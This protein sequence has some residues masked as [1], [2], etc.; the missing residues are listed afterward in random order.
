MNPRYAIPIFALTLIPSTA[1]ANA[2][3][4]LMW[5]SMLHLVFGNF[6]IGMI[7]GGLLAKIFNCSK[8]K[9]VPILIGA[10]YASAWA[11][12]FL[13]TRSLTSIP[14]LT[15]QNI[16]LWFLAFVAVA[17]L[18]TLLIEFPFFWFILRSK[19]KP[20]MQSIKATLLIHGISYILLFGWYWMASGT[21]M[22]TQLQVVSPNTLPLEKGY[23]LYYLSTEGN[24][25]L[26]LDLGSEATP[27]VV[28][29]ISAPH[30]NDRLFVRANGESNFDLFAHLDSD[31]RG[32]EK[33]I[34]ITPSFAEVAPVE[35]RIAEGHSEEAEGTWFNFGK[36]PSLAEN[37]AWEFRTGF[38]PIEGIKGEQK[39]QNKKVRFSLETPF[40][41][42][43][44]R[45]A[46]QLNGDFV[47]FQLGRDQICILHPES[48]KI[49]LIVRGKGPIV[50]KP[51]Q[52][53]K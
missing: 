18:V 4:P 10:N 53:N 34:L 2:G 23:S 36:A 38:W 26:R 17:F 42:W 1:S 15:I 29:E 37:S 44:A 22:M 41:A 16:Q 51:N 52:A 43:A 49:A 39:D 33:E 24:Q 27:K 25:V 7:E 20:V 31:Q 21:S 8:R 6:I 40:A 13:I 28:S 30:R 35:P 3:T 46:T 14:D 45:N 9:S 5:A 11:G 12:G 50:A 32:K 19:E 47:V 48:K